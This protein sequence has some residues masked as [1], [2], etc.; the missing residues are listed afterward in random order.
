MVLEE[1]EEEE[2]MEE[3]A[4]ASYPAKMRPLIVSE[5]PS[6]INSNF[7]PAS[8]S[9]AAAVA[10]LRAPTNRDAS[11]VGAASASSSSALSLL[12]VPDV[13]TFCSSRSPFCAFSIDRFTTLATRCVASCSSAALSTTTSSPRTTSTP[14][15]SS[16]LLIFASDLALQYFPLPS[17]PDFFVFCDP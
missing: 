15:A 16:S 13:A 7:L 10:A 5:M 4:A 12:S 14:T 1:I 11:I 3:E 9:A 2:V 17:A 6:L 8:A